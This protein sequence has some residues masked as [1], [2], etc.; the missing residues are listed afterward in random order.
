MSPAP[1]FPPPEIILV[2]FSLKRNGKNIKEN[3]GK[4]KYSFQFPPTPLL[5]ISY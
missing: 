1:P 4:K 3:K 5:T 2:W